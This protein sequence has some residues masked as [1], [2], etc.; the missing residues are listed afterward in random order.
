[1]AVRELEEWP[2]DRKDSS[3]GSENR[4]KWAEK[5]TAVPETLKEAWSRVNKGKQDNSEN[6]DIHS[7]QLERLNKKL[8]AFRSAVAWEC[9]LVCCP[10]SRFFD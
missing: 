9:F 6:Q 1:M 2:R 4:L 10:V 7:R 5:D 3:Q 8:A